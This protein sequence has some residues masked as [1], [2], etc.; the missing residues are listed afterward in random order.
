MTDKKRNESQERIAEELK[1]LYKK[2]HGLDPA[3]VVQWA[4]THRASA[5]HSRFEWDDTQA[6]ERYRIWQARELIVSV[7]VIYP[8]MKPRQVYVSPMESRGDGG[9]VALVE[10]L[11]N[12]Q[13]RA[14][15]LEQALAEFQ[16]F[17]AKYADLKELAE[18]FAAGRRVM[19][20]STKKPT[21][22]EVRPEA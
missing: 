9:Y 12:R 6:A 22:P 3:K 15:F 4:R 21:R 10:V 18:L 8:D 1:A 17:E 16:R 2:H 11:S 13:R 19:Q 14:A 5:L 7:D 20:R